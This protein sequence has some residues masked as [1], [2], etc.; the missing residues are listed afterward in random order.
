MSVASLDLSKFAFE[1]E[2]RTLT[3]VDRFNYLVSY[4]TGDGSREV[5]VSTRRSKSRAAYGERKPSLVP[6]WYFTEVE[7]SCKLSQCAQLGRMVA[8]HDV[9]RFEFFAHRCLCSIP[10][11]R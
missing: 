9:C 1:A 6:D 8:R 11:I 2:W 4:L 7:R 5:E 10:G 3:I